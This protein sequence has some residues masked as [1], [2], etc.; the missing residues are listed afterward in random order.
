MAEDIKAKSARKTGFLFNLG[1]GALGLG[2]AVAGALIPGLGTPF[3]I[4]GSG[5]VL[6][7]AK[8]PGRMLADKLMASPSEPPA[9]QP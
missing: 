7:A 5:M 8:S 2:I 6:H 9:N 3:V 4:V 1:Y